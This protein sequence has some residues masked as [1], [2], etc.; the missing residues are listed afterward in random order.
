MDG[1]VIAEMPSVEEIRASMANLHQIYAN[2]IDEHKLGDSY[3]F[4]ECQQY[5]NF[6]N[7][8][9]EAYGWGIQQRMKIIKFQHPATIPANKLPVDIDYDKYGN[10]VST[11]KG[12]VDC[13]ILSGEGAIWE[14]NP[15]TNANGK[16]K[17]WA[18]TIE[19]SC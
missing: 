19:N 17:N 4:L 6:I 8:I 2:S 18:M 10:E 15:P 16:E 13:R 9:A 7:N 14:L 1:G 3:N 5:Q 12:W 11:T